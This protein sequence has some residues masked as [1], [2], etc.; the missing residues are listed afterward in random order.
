VLYGLTCAVARQESG[1]NPVSQLDPSAHIPAEW[2]ARAVAWL[3]TSAASDLGGV[4]FSLKN[5]EGRRRA[6]LPDL[7]AGK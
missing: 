3:C 1:I 5:E 4:D 2:V 6:G 7:S